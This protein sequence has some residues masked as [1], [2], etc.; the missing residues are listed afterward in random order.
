MLVYYSS[1]N[2]YKGVGIMIFGNKMYLRSVVKEDIEALYNICTD[3]EVLKYNYGSVGIPSKG[4]IM[5]QFQHLNRPN[6]EELTI[7]NNDREVIGYV[8]YKENRYTIDTYS[9]GITIGRAYW[10]DGYGRDAT[11]QLCKYLFYKKKAHKIELEVVKENARAVNFYK[12]LG[13]IEEGV[14]RSKYYLKGEYLDT[15]V[16]GMLRAEFKL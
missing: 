12:E 8:Y 7:V 13:F 2:K 4:T 5:D 3:K 15:I 9:I 6:R 10:G 14:R 11:I 16:M 1:R